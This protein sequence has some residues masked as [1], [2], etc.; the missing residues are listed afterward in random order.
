MSEFKKEADIVEVL[1]QFKRVIIDIGK[2][3]K[4]K[5]AIQL[6][7]TIQGEFLDLHPLEVAE[8]EI[9]RLI[10]QRNIES[11]CVDERDKNIAELK[12]KVKQFRTWLKKEYPK[13]EPLNEKFVEV[14]GDKRDKIIP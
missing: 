11:K 4:T 14:F 8:A 5:E 6:V 3:A 12:G 9:N 1:R 7:S 2:K 13:Y 10:E